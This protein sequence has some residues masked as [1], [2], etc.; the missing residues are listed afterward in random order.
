MDNYSQFRSHWDD[1]GSFLHIAHPAYA[2]SR[3]IS[4]FIL[5]AADDRLVWSNSNKIG[6]Q[7]C[8]PNCGKQEDRAFPVNRGSL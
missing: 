6:N 4:S 2:R 5:D 8:V 1:V 3:V 7:F